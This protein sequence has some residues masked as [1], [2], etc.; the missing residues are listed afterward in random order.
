MGATAFVGD[1]GSSKTLA[2]SAWLQEGIEAGG[3]AAS[4]FGFKNGVH[5]RTSGELFSLIASRVRVPFRDRVPIRIAFDEARQLFSCRVRSSWPPVMDLVCDEARKLKVQIA[6]ATPNISRVD[7]NL[8]LATSRIVSCKGFLHKRVDHPDLGVIPQPRIG[9][10]TPYEYA[11]DKVGDRIKGER[12]FWTWGDVASYADLFDTSFLI[13]SI[14]FEL[15]KAASKADEADYGEADTHE[16]I[17]VQV[18]SL[19]RSHRS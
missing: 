7:V 18:G 10:W 5:F 15:E 3:E 13:E 2:M 6:Y 1:W 8:R 9:F 14:A 19:K 16:P 12:R 17:T 4:N 11:N